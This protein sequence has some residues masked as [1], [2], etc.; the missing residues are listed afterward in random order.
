MGIWNTEENLMASDYNDGKF[1]VI[2]KS[3]NGFHWIHCLQYNTIGAKVIQIK[4]NS[5]NFQIF[6]YN[7]WVKGKNKNCSSKLLSA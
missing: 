2:P 7:S 1:Q 5:G 6:S 4:R 3:R